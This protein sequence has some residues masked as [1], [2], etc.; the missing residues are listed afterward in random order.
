MAEPIRNTSPSELSKKLRGSYRSNAR[1]PRAHVLG[2]VNPGDHIQITLTIRRA[3]T[4]QEQS[5]NGLQAH[6]EEVSNRL[7]RERE[8]LTPEQLEASHGASLADLQQISTFAHN[9]DLEV[10]DAS[11]LKRS[12]LLRGSIGSLSSAFGINL[13]RYN[14]HGNI[15][16][17]RKGWVYV[18]DEISSIV[19]G[20]HGLDN[21]PHFERYPRRIVKT[22]RKGRDTE[23][24]RRRSHFA[25]I[26]KIAKRYN[27][28]TESR[29]GRVLDGAGVCIGIIESGGG[30]IPEELEKYFKD[31]KIARPPNVLAVSIGN[32]QNNPGS[33]LE[34]DGE[35]MLDIGIAGAI[36][37]AA[38]IVVYFCDGT[39][40]GSID[41]VKQAIYDREHN[42]SVISISWGA[43]EDKSR[44]SQ[45]MD[46]MNEVFQEAAALGKTIC[47][48]SGDNGS[49]D[50]RL[51]NGELSDN[52]A[53]VHFPASSPY[54][55][56]CGGTQLGRSANETV[57]NNKD[58]AT[59]GGVSDRFPRPGYQQG[60]KFPHS[61]NKTRFNGR[62]LPD[63]AGLA[64]PGYNIPVHGKV[65]PRGGTSAAAPLWAG[66]VALFNESI[67]KN[68]GFLN[69][70]L[71][72]RFGPAGVLNDVK[73]GNNRTKK[74]LAKRS[75]SMKG[76]T[77]TKGY[78]AARGWDPCTG[79]GTPNGKKLLRA[80]EG[81]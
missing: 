11:L 35:V 9:H 2:P 29:D 39:T 12:V 30:F 31:L 71:Y 14:Y 22:G 69:P 64:S 3:T 79:F 19:S 73:N 18:P 23:A 44:G 45:Y 77:M 33:D 28:P 75:T 15:Y 49:S 74:I 5:P 59:G 56:A 81:I 66:L 50:L 42:P 62:G 60:V 67:G 40:N 16:R 43:P 26:K 65:E 53:H 21:R 34:A 61:A 1:I 68:V 24:P 57:W 48:S 25:T 76:F 4:E 7:P 10:V 6:I 72:M 47:C 58:G 63:V 52:L 38:K 80:L 55:L 27:F 41:A 46:S 70:L 8:Y 78:K 20:V 51:Q 37:P 54:V 13:K 36:A 32:S 17:G